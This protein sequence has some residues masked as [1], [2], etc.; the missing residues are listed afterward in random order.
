[1]RSF[2]IFAAIFI[3]LVLSGCSTTMRG[4]D[5]YG[6]PIVAEVPPA[7]VETTEV[8]NVVDLEPKTVVFTGYTARTIVVRTSERALY[9]VISDE[10]AVRIPV[11]VGKEGFEWTGEA[12]IGD[13]QID[14][15][16]T[17]PESMIERRP[18][19]ARWAGGMPGGI[20]ENPLG[21]R[22]LYLYTDEGVDTMYRIHGT[23]APEAIGTAASSGCIR[24]LNDHVEALYQYVRLGD[25]V[26][27]EN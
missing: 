9:V 10:E 15:T 14:P 5:A 7:V 12:I 6:T 20:R 4:L 8:V 2:Q 22:A 19:L 21:S 17:P 16:W 27:V 18:E 26:I 13:K 23:N 3:A 25:R 11:A 1:M 24:M